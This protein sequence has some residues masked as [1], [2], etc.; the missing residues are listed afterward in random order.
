MEKKTIEIGDKVNIYL[1][2]EDSY[3]NAEILYLPQS[4]G[5]CWHIKTDDGHIAYVQQ[6]E[7]IVLLKVNKK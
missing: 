1:L 5:D 4:T 6:F 2:N 3:M 7:S